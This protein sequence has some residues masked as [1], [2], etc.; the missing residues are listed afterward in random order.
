MKANLNPWIKILGYQRYQELTTKVPEPPDWYKL[1]D[2]ELPPPPS[3][4]VRDPTSH[5]SRIGGV[6]IAAVEEI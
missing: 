1:I 3:T 2:I 6:T 5:T 4:G